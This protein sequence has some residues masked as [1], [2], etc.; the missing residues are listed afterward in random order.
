MQALPMVN[1]ISFKNILFLTDFSE[2][3]NAAQAYAVGLARHY[4]AQLYPAHACNPI[5][6][7]ETAGTDII[8]EMEDTS[9]ERLYALARETGLDCTPLFA[10]GAVEDTI[11]EWSREH[12]IDLIVMGT[13]GRRGLRH[14]LM[15][16]VAEAVF[17]KASCPVLTVGPHV[18]T[19]PYHNFKVESILFPTDLGS[20]VEF[21]ARYAL[22]VAQEN[23]AD[24]T[25]MHVIAPEQI[26]LTDR[27]SLVNTTYRKLNKIVPA[28]AKSWCKPQYV[29]EVGDPVKE[30]M[31]Y[32]EKERPDMI[33]LGLPAEKRF[34]DHFHTGVTYNVIASAPCPVLTLRDEPSPN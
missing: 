20:H 34:N 12:G 16:S 24:I 5:I 2:A 21:A 32:A 33:V 9:R 17:R 18:H 22:S 11:P 3:S 14:F 30:L 27:A 26:H 31:N 13:H 29:V 15:G 10:R 7:T 25:F 28:E 8:Q 6:L 4:G 1:K 19:R 23:Y